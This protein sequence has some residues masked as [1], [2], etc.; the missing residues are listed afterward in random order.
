MSIKEFLLERL[1]TMNSNTVN[2][3]KVDSDH[4]DN[5]F[6]EFFRAVVAVDA[7]KTLVSDGAN[8]KELSETVKD[9]RSARSLR[10]WSLI[11]TIMFPIIP[12]I[13]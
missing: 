2:E 6:F 8:V 7:L 5:H 13:L 3:A 1:N 11:L 9:F 4:I 12:I 10:N